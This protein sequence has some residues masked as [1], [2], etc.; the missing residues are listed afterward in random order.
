MQ[1]RIRLSDAERED[2]FASLRAFQIP[3]A[4]LFAG[5]PKLFL[6]LKK[7]IAEV[8][9]VFGVAVPSPRGGIVFHEIAMP[10]LEEYRLSSAAR[11]VEDPSDDPGGVPGGTFVR[12]RVEDG[13]LRDLQKEYGGESLLETYGYV[14]TTWIEMLRVA[15]GFEQGHVVIHSPKQDRFYPI[16][17]PAGGDDSF[18]WAREAAP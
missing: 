2:L 16:T 7:T 11:F 1:V 8:E 3:P 15:R 17:A 5:F 12:A 14:L 18:P 10:S 6:L 9:G 4:D 13:V